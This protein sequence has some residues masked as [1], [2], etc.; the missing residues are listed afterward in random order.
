M[1]RELY[2]EL[3]QITWRLGQSYRSKHVIHADAEIVLVYF[4]AVLH[5]RP[6][7]WACRKTNWPAQAR[8]DLPSASAMSR[9]LRGAPVRTFVK[10]VEQRLQKTCRQYEGMLYLDGK[11]LPVGG[12]SGDP[13]A[14]NGYGAGKIARGYRLHAICDKAQMP[15]AWCVRPLNE[16]EPVVALALVEGL[17]RDGYLIAD[18]NYDSNRLYDQAGTEGLQLLTPRRKGKALGH[19]QHSPYRRRAYAMDEQTRASLLHSRGTIESF[20]GTLCSGTGGL[21]ALP[22]WVRRLHR[23]ELWVRAKIIL[24]YLRARRRERRRSA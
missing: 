11:P 7:C 9:R 13:D 15:V 22:S 24:Y 23:V 21:L 18:G 2:R 6:V 4:W 8:R 14:T 16:A 17:R 20:F 12:M 1:E 5:D 3:Y 10:A 19:R